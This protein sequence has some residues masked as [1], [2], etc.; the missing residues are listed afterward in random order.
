[1]GRCPLTYGP[2]ETGGK[3][4]AATGLPLTARYATALEQLVTDHYIEHRLA[5]DE[6]LTARD[7]LEHQLNVAPRRFDPSLGATTAHDQTISG[8][9]QCHRTTLVPDAC[10]SN[11]ASNVLHTPACKNLNIGKLERIMHTW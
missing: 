1:M 8:R 11:F 3:V 10:S 5:R 7:G 9:G 6:W 4:D 2:N